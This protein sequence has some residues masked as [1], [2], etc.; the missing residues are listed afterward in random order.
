MSCQP[1]VGLVGAPRGAGL[2]V[3]FRS[4]MT[5]IRLDEAV[6]DFRH[7]FGN[8][9][10]AV[11]RA[12]GRVSLMGSHTDYNEG[13]VLPAAID[14]DVLI[15][16]SPRQGGQVKLRSLNYDQTTEF[17]VAA[18]TSS[19]DAPWSNYVRGVAW[20]LMAAGH[21][22]AGL[23]AVIEGNVPIGAGLS[24][25]AAVEVA[26]A[27]AFCEAS[28]LEIPRPELAQLCQRAENEFVGMNC[29]I[30]DQFTSL[31]AEKGHALF[32]DCRSLGYRNVPFDTSEVKVVICDTKK[33]RELVHSEYNTRRAECEEG[34]RVLGVPAL[35]DATLE[36]FRTHAAD[37]T[38]TIRRRCRHIITENDRV[39]RSLQVLEA[40]DLVAFGALMNEAHVSIRD[41]YEASG[42]ELEVMIEIAQQTEGVL[43]S[44]ATGAGW[45][46]C[47]ANLVRGDAVERLKQNVF[48][49]YPPRTGLTPDVYVCEA[50]AG[51][52]VVAL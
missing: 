43:G 18:V 4:V 29:G 42:P 1:K 15:A 10:A 9:P 51:A 7:H 11:V 34:A 17:D 40:G 36:L 5:N 52:E 26:S 37:L 21:E 27:L 13:Y 47:T 46:G 41:D 49:E 45:G 12:P 3:G 23:D 20:S 38:E 30:L 24:S 8:P 19:A 6:A 2:V 48:E 16:L 31:M 50:A 35:R 28:K 25:S 39:L 33:P 14:F 22:L 32:L 44:L